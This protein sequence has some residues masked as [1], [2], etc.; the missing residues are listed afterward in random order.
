MKR[1]AFIFSLVGCLIALAGCSSKPYLTES[2]IMYNGNTAT[3][4]ILTGFKTNLNGKYTRGSDD[5][6]I[7]DDKVTRISRIAK[8]IGSTEYYEDKLVYEHIVRLSENILR[9]YNFTYGYQ[10][11]LYVDGDTIY[12]LSSEQAWTKLNCCNKSSLNMRF[13]DG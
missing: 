8:D 13:I 1:I 10:L 3:T 2:Q 12:I 7:E 9:C 4:Q 6:I 5:I 11:V